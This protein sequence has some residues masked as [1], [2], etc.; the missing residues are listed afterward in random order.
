LPGGNNLVTGPYNP[1]APS[2]LHSSTQEANHT[3]WR[4]RL[5]PLL[6]DDRVYDNGDAQ[7]YHRTPRTPF[8]R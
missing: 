1:G 6:L 2:A 5:P 3:A 7:I 4:F 8:Q